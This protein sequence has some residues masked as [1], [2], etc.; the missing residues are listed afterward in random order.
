MT[1]WELGLVMAATGL[2][3]V[4]QAHLG[5]RVWV[6]Q[7]LLSQVQNPRGELLPLQRPAPSPVYN[8]GSLA[9]ERVL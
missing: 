3:P 4:R 7:R 9:K 5:W 1:M 8:H 2:L 6:R